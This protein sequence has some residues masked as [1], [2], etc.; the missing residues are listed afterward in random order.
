MAEDLALR[1][2]LAMAVLV[3]GAAAPA[4]GEEAMTDPT[5]PA[6]LPEPAAAAGAAAQGP[7]LQSV[8]ISPE[9]RLAVIDGRTVPL[10]GRFGSATLI[11]VTET[12]VVLKDESGTRRLPLLP[13]VDKRAAAG[14]GADAKPAAPAGRAGKERGEP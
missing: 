5:R 12:G 2:F 8:L 6:S 4:A 3:L 7:V 11:G 13:G 9:R 10:G 14:Q 1:D